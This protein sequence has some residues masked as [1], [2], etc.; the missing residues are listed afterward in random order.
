[1]ERRERRG[2][3]GGREEAGETV[4]ERVVMGG[5]VVVRGRAGEYLATG[6]GGFIEAGTVDG[7][8]YE[9]V[10]ALQVEGGW[11][12]KGEGKKLGLG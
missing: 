9:V 11:G 12:T 1:M 5:M 3:F 4:A 10:G 6:A 7:R 2:W 8:D